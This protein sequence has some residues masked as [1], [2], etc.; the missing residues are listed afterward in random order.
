[1]LVWTLNDDESPNIYELGKTAKLCV[2]YFLLMQRPESLQPAQKEG[3][4]SPTFAGQIAK[5]TF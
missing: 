2:A 5:L 3:Y 4:W 1:M